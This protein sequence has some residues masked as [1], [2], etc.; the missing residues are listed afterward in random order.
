MLLDS[1]EIRGSVGIG[2]FHPS[3]GNIYGTKTRVVNAGDGGGSRSTYS[4]G[5][6]AVGSGRN[7][8]GG[9]RSRK[10]EAIVFST[11]ELQL[12]LGCA[13]PPRPPLSLKGGAGRQKCCN[14]N[15]GERKRGGP[16]TNVGRAAV[17]TPKKR[18]GAELPQRAA[19]PRDS[20]VCVHKK[21]R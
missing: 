10:A 20:S 3:R 4:E 1:L 9:G 21:V 17:R 5:K 16:S 2:R 12:S 11:S 15:G 7:K 8:K 13:D 14:S 6:C 19:L 18:L